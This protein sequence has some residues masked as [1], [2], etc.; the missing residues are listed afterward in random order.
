[1]QSL[2]HAHLP[3]NIVFCCVQATDK[4]PIVVSETHAS[5]LA[6]REMRL[7]FR[8]L[9]AQARLA[10]H[11]PQTAYQKAFLQDSIRCLFSV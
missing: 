10:F 7:C 5:T 6:A 9:H 3:A 4:P 1:M 8:R 11:V 2:I